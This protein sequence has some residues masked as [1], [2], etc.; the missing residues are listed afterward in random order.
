MNRLRIHK[1]EPLRSI[2]LSPWTG[3]DWGGVGGGV[4]D[5]GS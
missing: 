4:D 2:F 5:H 1:I 3:K